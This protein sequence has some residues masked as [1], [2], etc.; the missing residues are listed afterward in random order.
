LTVS[1]TDTGQWLRIQVT[2]VD[3]HGAAG[4]PIISDPLRVV[5]GT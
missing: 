3:E 2:P 1:G 4:T 5:S